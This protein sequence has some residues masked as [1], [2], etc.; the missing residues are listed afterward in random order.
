[1]NRNY[2]GALSINDPLKESTFTRKEWTAAPEFVHVFPWLITWSALSYGKTGLKIKIWIAAK[3]L[4]FFLIKCIMPHL[5]R[6][7]IST[8]QCIQHLSGPQFHLI[9]HLIKNIL[10]LWLDE[11]FHKLYT[12]SGPQQTE[13]NMILMSKHM[14]LLVHFCCAH[15]QSYSS[16]WLQWHEDF[17]KY[18]V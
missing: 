8:T 16:L 7:E 4:P 13:R 15:L 17:Y 5:N 1:M 2:N 9:W 18:S 14:P 12:W 3:H 10:H 6:V 11:W